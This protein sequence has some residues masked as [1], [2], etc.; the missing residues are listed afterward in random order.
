MKKKPA[1]QNK[2]LEDKPNKATTYYGS[3]TQGGS[4]FGQGS[5]QLGNKSIKQGSESG[6]G[7][8]YDD[9]GGWNNEA[10]RK[11]DM[12]KQ[13]KD[14]VIETGFLYTSTIIA[15]E[16]FFDKPAMSPN[17]QYKEKPAAKAGN[18]TKA[19]GNTGTKAGSKSAKN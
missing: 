3:T 15:M 16:N 7:S 11:S 8:N 17:K 19:T 18:N 12:Q 14:I 4:N 13:E 2:V 5:L 10:L 9:E 6:P 1:K